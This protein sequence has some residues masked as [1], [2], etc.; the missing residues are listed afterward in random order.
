MPLR[1]RHHG[2]RLTSTPSHRAT[3][4][5]PAGVHVVLCCV[6]LYCVLLQCIAT[7]SFALHFHLFP[8]SIVFIYCILYLSVAYL[9][10]AFIYC[11]FICCIFIYFLRL[12]HLSIAYLSVA[13]HLNC[14]SSS[15]TVDSIPARDSVFTSHG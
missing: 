1:L 3:L 12:L 2:K 14:Y 9:S 11:I 8:S 13:L 4:C 6:F 5:C 7:P 15:S 10:F